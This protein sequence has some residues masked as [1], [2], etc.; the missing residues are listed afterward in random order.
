MPC[1]NCTKLNFKHG[2]ELY[3]REIPT[4]QCLYDLSIDI[5]IKLLPSLSEEVG[6]EHQDVMG[7][8]AR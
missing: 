7:C 8:K 5:E 6:H 4:K 2:A 1:V 3:Q